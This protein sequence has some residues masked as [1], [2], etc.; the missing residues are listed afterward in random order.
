MY[1]ESQDSWQE[2]CLEAARQ[3]GRSCGKLE[4]GV[5]INRPIARS[6]SRDLAELILNGDERGTTARAAAKAEADGSEFVDR[7]RAGVW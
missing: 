1:S 6:M 4:R 5:V 3:C 7:L 2:V